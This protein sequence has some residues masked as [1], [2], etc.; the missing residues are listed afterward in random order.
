MTPLVTHRGVTAAI[1]R[2]NID[3]DAIIPSREM[4]LVSKQGLGEGLFAGWRYTQVGG[5][6]PNPDFILNKPEYRGT[7]ILLAGKNFG[8]GSSREHAVWA[9]AEYGIRV[10]IAPSF[11]AI[12]YG[13][14]VRNGILPVTLA[15]EVI[16]AMAE[17]IKDPQRQQLHVDL[18]KLLVTAVDGSQ[19]AFSI[20]NA[21]QQ[22][23]L[24]G[25]DQIGLTL[26]RSATIADF[27]VSLRRRR[28]WLFDL[29]TR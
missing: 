20:S 12:F 5:R 19:H 23:L 18:E 9:L 28:P 21:N 24:E 7:S 25:L 13:N 29:T 6:E 26:K 15:D 10:I 22:M 16:V 3:T 27:E 17:Q 1:L 11:G 2:T 14:C 8:C 4:K